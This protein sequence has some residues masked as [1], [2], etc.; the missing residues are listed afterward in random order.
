M[1]N[2][3]ENSS[4]WIWKSKRGYWNGNREAFVKDKKDATKEK[5]MNAKLSICVGDGEWV[6]AE[7][8]SVTIQ[9]S[10]F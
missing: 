2:E 1:E 5:W 9:P 7:D 10:T 6:S 8:D 3:P 4:L